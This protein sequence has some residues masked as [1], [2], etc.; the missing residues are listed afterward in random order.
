MKQLVRFQVD[1]QTIVTEVELPEAGLERMAREDQVVDATMT[2]DE[3]L[4][5]VIPVV[6]KIIDRLRGL[7]PNEG[8]VQFG[9]KLS[10]QIGAVLASAQAEGNFQVTLSW[11][12]QEDTVE[13]PN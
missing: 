6:K 3:A 1:N 4:N 2:F 10:G 8:N 5:Q 7:A 13:S 9:I 12:K 11:K